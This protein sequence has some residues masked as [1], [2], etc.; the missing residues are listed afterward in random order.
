MKLAA[1]GALG[2]A[3]AYL[4]LPAASAPPKPAAAPVK[5]RI[6]ASARKGMDFLRK[7]QGQDGSWQGYPGITA[8]C[9]MGFLRNGVGEKDPAVAKACA[10][11]ASQAKPDGGIYTEKL[12]PAQRLPNYNTALSMTALYAAG[13]P[14]YREIVSRAQR[15]LE[16]TQLDEKKG[17][18]PNDRQYGGIAYG[19]GEANPDLSNLQH[20]LEALNETG[21]PKNAE[22]FKKAL[23]FLQRC[24]NRKDSNDQS[25]AGN[26]GG[27]IYAASGES[28]ADEYTKQAHSSYGSM[29]YAGLKSYLYCSVSKTDPRVQSA[30]NWL[31]A[32]Y[33][34]EQNPRMGNDGLYYYYHT[35]SKTLSVWGDK[36]LVDA[37][38]QKP[39]WASDLARAIVTRQRPDGAWSNQNKRWR[40][41][42]PD[43]ATGYA[44]IALANCLKGL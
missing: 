28:K 20:A 16:G 19:T 25:W 7:T 27:F 22:V 13:N 12:G 2:M 40:E 33:D 38:G 35:M 37:A 1:L 32:N 24:Q 17:F 21:E 39:P 15:F 3:A 23:V 42:Q 41:D 11:L 18:S 4:A 31:R 14:K 10:Y 36:T 44:L 8:I 26:D 9:L 5:T 43:L 6:A 34:V 29:T 30:F